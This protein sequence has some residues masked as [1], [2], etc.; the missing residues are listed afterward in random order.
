MTDN[1]IIS[2]IVSDKKLRDALMR[3]NARRKALQQAFPGCRVDRMSRYFECRDR[4]TF[5]AIS[6]CL[7]GISKQYI[8]GILVRALQKLRKK[9]RLENYHDYADMLN[10]KSATSKCCIVVHKHATTRQR[11]SADGY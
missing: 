8:Q 6:I 5:Q 7:G 4:M 9:I 10:R 3:E 1:E 2:A 11:K